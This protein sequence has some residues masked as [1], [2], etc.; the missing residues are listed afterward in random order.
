MGPAMQTGVN[1]RAQSLYGTNPA[2]SQQAQTTD[3]GYFG[4]YNT[5]PSSPEYQQNYQTGSDPNGD[6]NVMMQQANQY[7]YGMGNSLQN[8]NQAYASNQ[9]LASQS[10]RNDAYPVAQNM[11]AG[12]GGYSPDEM[13]AI[14]RTSEY[15]QGVASPT[16]YASMAPTSA[17][18][19]GMTGDT[20]SYY[21]WFNPQ[22]MSDMQTGSAQAQRNY[23]NQMGTQQGD[24][25]GQMQ[26]SYGSALQNQGLNYDP[27]GV[28]SALTAGNAGIQG[29]YDPNSLQQNAN[30]AKNY[31]MSD[32][33]VQAMQNQAA[34][35]QHNL[36]QGKFDQIQQA[37]A[38]SGYNSPM[39]LAHA[40]EQLQLQGDINAGDEALNA[41]VAAKNMQAQRLY[42]TETNRQQTAANAANTNIGVASNIANR[43]LST[44]SNT[45]GATLGAQQNL[46]GMQIGA[47][48]NLA[49]QRVGA[50]NTLGS[51]GAG[52]EAGIGN[53]AQNTQQ[54][55]T[56]TGTGIA[57]A[58][59]TANVARQ[60]NLYGIRQGNQQYQ[61]GNT[62]NQN[63]A[64][65]DRLSNSALQGA[66]MRINQQNA[67]LG[68]Y[69]GQQGLANQ[70]V[71][72][73]MNRQA[74]LY[75]TQANAA[76]AVTGQKVNQDNSTRST[77]FG[78]ALGQGF[79]R[80]LGGSLGSISY[81][82]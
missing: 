41:Q 70:N 18:Q 3:P 21:N 57:Q 5:L 1:R 28:N 77:S 38:N 44:A 75:G 17:E 16:Q 49:Q 40:N 35:T 62:F 50:A 14:T 58:Q 25:L 29:S 59:D 82:G 43:G 68:W 7:I 36:A 80:A 67:G 48:G 15:E 32:A 33:D 69:T 8:Q 53:Q 54:Y 30:F 9:D 52:T 34:T 56:N 37:A 10:F 76:N 66:N 63:L 81:G 72:N 27:S 42:G 55:I 6:P 26:T 51:L 20:G 22:Q 45:A 4:Q 64:T 78:T 73:T 2:Q 19:A 11:L 60:N 65:Q 61:I 71:Q 31:Q 46:A 39:A 23:L 47:A 12:H 74:S 79:G 13:G 24:A